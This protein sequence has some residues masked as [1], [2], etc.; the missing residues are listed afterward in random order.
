MPNTPVPN[1]LIPLFKNDQLRLSYLINSLILF[2]KVIID[3]RHLIELKKLTEIF[4]TRNIRKLITSGNI[5]VKGGHI[6]TGVQLQKVRGGDFLFLVRPMQLEPDSTKKKNIQGLADHLEST[7]E[8][9]RIF[10][11]S[12][13][14]EIWKKYN[15]EKLIEE[16]LD[17]YKDYSDESFSDFTDRVHGF[18]S[19]ENIIRQAL[20]NESFQ[21]YLNSD[22][23]N[24][25][26]VFR[27]EKEIF[28]LNFNQRINSG[29]QVELIKKWS[30]NFLLGMA[31]IIRNNFNELYF[32]SM[33][34]YK[35]DEIDF[36]KMNSQYIYQKFDPHQQLERHERVLNINNLPLVEESNVEDIKFKNFYKALK[37][38]EISKFR[39]WLW[40]IDNL[41]DNNLTEK[42]N[43][44]TKRLD[45]IFR[46]PLLKGSIDILQ[47]FLVSS[48]IGDPS[49]VTGE[50]SGSLIDQHIF[51]KLKRK[52]H[53]TFINDIYPSIFEK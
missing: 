51:K 34:G 26:Q 28:R 12:A 6:T 38:N 18:I 49:G 33:V 44:L 42:V 37:S 43:D 24:Q 27:E 7:S 13:I 23:S 53:F 36:Q 35:N 10:L 11:I 14:I 45:K 41:S 25:I 16:V 5:E 30:T 47:S 19:D 15:R 29:R 40:N 32:N 31:N 2:D 46:I 22:D 17:V 9:N 50:L 21:T 3:S 52:D 8:K 4:G 20:I 1:I 39:N 48:S